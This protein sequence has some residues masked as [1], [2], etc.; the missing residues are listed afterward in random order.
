M[1]CTVCVIPGCMLQGVCRV[2]GSV[3]SAG[4]LKILFRTLFLIGFI[5]L[6]YMYLDC[7]FGTVSCNEGTMRHADLGLYT[8][9]MMGVGLGGLIFECFLWFEGKV[10]CDSYHRVSSDD[11]IV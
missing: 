11:A 5:A 4:H 1:A 10:K 9:M 6:A 8:G 2:W 3:S 7:T